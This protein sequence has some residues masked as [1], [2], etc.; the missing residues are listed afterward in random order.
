MITATFALGGP[1]L[2]VLV[3]IHHELKRMNDREEKKTADPDQPVTN[4]ER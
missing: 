1:I 4:G 2:I 3:M